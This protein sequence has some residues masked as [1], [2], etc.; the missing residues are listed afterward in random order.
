MK[1]IF[2][3]EKLERTACRSILLMGK[4][5]DL[6]S[7]WKTWSKKN[8]MKNNI[9]ECAQLLNAWRAKKPKKLT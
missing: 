5:Q 1:L 3:L 6:D 9:K 7:T 8:P 4:L 2:Q